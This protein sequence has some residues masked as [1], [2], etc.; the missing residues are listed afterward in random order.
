MLNR[1]PC[2]FEVLLDYAEQLLDFLNMDLLFRP[3][4]N[5]HYKEV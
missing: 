1:N 2:V 5:T 3:Y 4:N